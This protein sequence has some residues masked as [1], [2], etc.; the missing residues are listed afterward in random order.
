MDNTIPTCSSYMFADLDYNPDKSLFVYKTLWDTIVDL[1][2][3]IKKSF[4]LALGWEYRSNINKFNMV[5]LP[6]AKEEEAIYYAENTAFCTSA[7]WDLLAQ[8]YNVKHKRNNNQ[9]KVYYS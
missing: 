3:K 6:S 5:G 8:L 2:R 7:L 9:D 1:D 4:D